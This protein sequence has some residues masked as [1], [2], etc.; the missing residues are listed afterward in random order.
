MGKKWRITMNKNAISKRKVN[1]IIEKINSKNGDLSILNENERMIYYNYMCDKIGLDPATRPF[2]FINLD[3]KIILY[4]TKSCSDQLRLKHEISTESIEV[5][6]HNNIVYCK[7][8]I[9][10]KNGRK[11]CAIGS[12]FLE[13]DK[14]LNAADKIMK[15]ETKAKRRATLSMFA[16]SV[17]DETE[18]YSIQNQSISYNNQTSQQTN[19]ISNQTTQTNYTKQELNKVQS[20]NNREDSLEKFK[21]ISEEIKEK[22]K[23]LNMPKEE[24]IKLCEFYKWNEQIIIPY[25]DKLIISSKLNNL[26]DNIKSIARDLQM[27]RSEILEICEKTNWDHAKITEILSN[28]YQEKFNMTPNEKITTESIKKNLNKTQKKE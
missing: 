7:A 9:V 26:P 6:F 14:K 17:L 1:K 13:P 19:N 18:I 20:V 8:T 4:A 3:G 23:E 12:E 16:I 24:L 28:I 5:Y 10:D 22:A 11:E 25:L 21:D 27:K 15:A 2:D